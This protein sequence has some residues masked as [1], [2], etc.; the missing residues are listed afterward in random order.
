MQYPLNCMCGTDLGLPDRCRWTEVDLVVGKGPWGFK[1]P[2]ITQSFNSIL[3]WSL[4]TIS[5]P[6]ILFLN[7]VNIVSKQKVLSNNKCSNRHVLYQHVIGSCIL[8]TDKTQTCSS[9][10]IIVL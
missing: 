10:F 3:L 2:V 8:K 5:Q 4:G 1:L 9:L 6:C 7:P